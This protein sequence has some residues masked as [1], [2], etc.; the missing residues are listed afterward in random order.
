MLWLTGGRQDGAGGRWHEQNTPPDREVREDPADWNK[1]GEFV[2]SVTVITLR[3]GI[4][5]PRFIMWNLRFK[6]GK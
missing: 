2:I 4:G 6:E 5:T 3:T 1:G